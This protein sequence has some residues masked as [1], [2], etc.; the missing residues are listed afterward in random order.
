[1]VGDPRPW[2]QDDPGMLGGPAIAQS[3]FAWLSRKLGEMNRRSGYA[4]VHDETY[5]RSS[6]PYRLSRTQDLIRVEQSLRT[7]DRVA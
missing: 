4:Q 5:L 1:M 6:L 7:V 2:F 3:D